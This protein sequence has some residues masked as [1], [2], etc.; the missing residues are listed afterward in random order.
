MASIRRLLVVTLASNVQLCRQR[1][2]PAV[3]G[4]G[5]NRRL[6]YC[7]WTGM[8]KTATQ[9]SCGLPFAGK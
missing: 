7:D 1:K 2:S 8:L 5:M 4:C 3:R 6:A 9:E